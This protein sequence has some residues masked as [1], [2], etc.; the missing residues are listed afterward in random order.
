MDNY[1]FSVIKIQCEN[2]IPILVQVYHLNWPSA[3]AISTTARATPLIT[4]PL[5]DSTLFNDLLELT[6]DEKKKKKAIIT[7]TVSEG[8]VTCA[9]SG[10]LPVFAQ[11]SNPSAT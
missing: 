5:L 9:S 3:S 4:Q 10:R 11:L 6:I 2:E 7:K 1:P 8:A